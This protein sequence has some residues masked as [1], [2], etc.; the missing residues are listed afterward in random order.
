MTV[1]PMRQADIARRVSNMARAP[2]CGARPALV[3]PAGKRP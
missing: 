2:R 1:D 3:I